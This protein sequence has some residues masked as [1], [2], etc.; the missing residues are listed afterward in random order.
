[1]DEDCREISYLFIYFVPTPDQPGD[2][3]ASRVSTR[4]HNRMIAWR[5]MKGLTMVVRFA[6]S[7]LSNIPTNYSCPVHFCNWKTGV[8]FTSASA[9]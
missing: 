3:R 7:M 6:S 4:I 9:L 2:S 8:S 1:M 5:C